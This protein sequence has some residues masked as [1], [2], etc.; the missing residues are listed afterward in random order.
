[1]TS[2]TLEVT[3]RRVIDDSDLRNRATALGG[4]IQAEDGPG[5]AVALLEQLVAD[6]Q[7]REQRQ[8]TETTHS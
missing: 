7:Q 1:M 5:R 8:G 6:S 4:R 3:L 2:S